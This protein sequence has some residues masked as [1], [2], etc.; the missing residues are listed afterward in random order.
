MKNFLWAYL[1]RSYH[2]MI[3]YIRELIICNQITPFM[4]REF[5][6]HMFF[7]CLREVVVW[8]YSPLKFCSFLLISSS[9]VDMWDEI[10]S[11]LY[12]IVM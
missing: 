8:L 5:L 4:M 1:L 2:E 9:V 3:Y 6:I 12:I 7:K 10:R 11:P